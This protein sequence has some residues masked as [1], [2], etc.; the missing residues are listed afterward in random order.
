MFLDPEKH[1]L[2]IRNI[3]TGKTHHVP[4]AELPDKF[5]G[6]G[7]EIRE[8]VAERPDEMVA[9]KVDV[10]D[11]SAA[12]VSFPDDMVATPQINVTSMDQLATD[13]LARLAL[14]ALIK[15]RIGEA[16][17]GDLYWHGGSEPFEH[18]GQQMDADDFLTAFLET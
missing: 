10:G 4:I 9:E 11:L 17:G 3:E 16:E 15:A 1:V 13:G 2:H 18:N 14:R 6:G 8:G 7:I 5:G 12:D